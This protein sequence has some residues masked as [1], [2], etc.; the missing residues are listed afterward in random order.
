MAVR[1]RVKIIKRGLL[2][3]MAKRQ[4]GITWSFGGSFPEMKKELG[5]LDVESGTSTTV[6]NVEV[7]RS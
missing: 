3:A 1:S 2:P 4:E 7:Q 5:R 6:A